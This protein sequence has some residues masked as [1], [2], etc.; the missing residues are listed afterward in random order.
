[1][2]H[3]RLVR[4]INHD[5]VHQSSLADK[6]LTYEKALEL[7]LVIEYAEKDTK[8]MKIANGKPFP[9]RCLSVPRPS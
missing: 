8:E 2:L 6:G 4:G 1:M 5:D 7:A 3:G 9:A